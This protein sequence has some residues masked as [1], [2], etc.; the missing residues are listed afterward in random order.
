MKKF[1]IYKA[2]RNGRLMHITS[3][4]ATDRKEAIEMFKKDNKSAIIG[5]SF[6]NYYVTGLTR[7]YNPLN[8]IK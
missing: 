8:Q 1:Q 3:Y 6:W 5:L 4:S 7:F 2:V